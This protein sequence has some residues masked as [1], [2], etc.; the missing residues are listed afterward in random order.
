MIHTLEITPELDVK[1]VKKL[2]R[3]YAMTGGYQLKIK[4]DLN[5]KELD[6]IAERFLVELREYP[7]QTSEYRACNAYRILRMVLERG[8]DLLESSQQLKEALDLGG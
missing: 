6:L 5:T 2:S 8:G 4:D 3:R 1:Q 7:F